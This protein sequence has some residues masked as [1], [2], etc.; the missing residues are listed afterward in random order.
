MFIKMILSKIHFCFKIWMDKN[1]KNHRFR[2]VFVTFLHYEFI[3]ANITAVGHISN[4]IFCSLDMCPNSISYTKNYQ[5]LSHGLCH[6]LPGFFHGQPLK[7]G[8]TS[9]HEHRSKI[10]LHKPLS[11][12]LKIIITSM[13]K[14]LNCKQELQRCAHELLGCT[15]ELL[16]YTH[17]L[18][19][20]THKLLS[21]ATWLELRVRV[22]L[23]YFK[24]CTVYG[25]PY[26]FLIYYFITLCLCTTFLSPLL[27]C[28][29]LVLSPIRGI[30]YKFLDV[31]PFV[32]TA[33][34]VSG[35]V[36]RP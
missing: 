3:M 14:L 28:W 32:Y 16:I 15:H 9:E 7:S 36:E 18:Q 22:R 24:N 26:I 10:L 2:P 13:H 6:P 11:A 17:E 33:A 23:D 20:Y 34:V 8:K 29:L 25:Y 31:C 12:K 19:T 4:F 30:I 5:N 35:K 21:Y 27:F 1:C